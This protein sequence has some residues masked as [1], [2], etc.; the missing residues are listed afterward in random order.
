MKLSTSIKLKIKAIKKFA[1]LIVR[2]IDK[3]KKIMSNIFNCFVDY[4][5]VI[6]FTILL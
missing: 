1:W 3:I 4:F 5:I 2:L 6:R